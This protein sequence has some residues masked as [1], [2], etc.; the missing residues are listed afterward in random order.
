LIINY[1]YYYYYYYYWEINVIV[2][3]QEIKYTYIWNPQRIIIIKIYILSAI[4][5]IPKV[6]AYYFSVFVNAVAVFKYVDG[7]K[8]ETSSVPS[9][10]LCIAEK[11][12]YICFVIYSFIFSSFR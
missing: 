11:A 12:S 5:L 1:Y 4:S 3:T 7:F 9:V 6:S 2:S 8:F 10:W